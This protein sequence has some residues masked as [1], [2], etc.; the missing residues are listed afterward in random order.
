LSRLERRNKARQIAANKHQDVLRA[1]K[2]FDGRR[3]AAR[4]ISIVPLCSDVSAAEVVQRLNGSLDINVDVPASGVITIGIERF[5]QK[6][7][8]AIPPQQDFLAVLDACKL[9]DFVIFILSAKE[10]VDTHGESL[11]RA[12][13]SQG[14]SNV[15]TVVQHLDTVEPAK[16]RPDVRKSLLSFITHFFPTTE[17]VHS[18]DATQ[19]AQ[20][21]VRSL[22]TQNP[23]GIRWRDARS[24]ILAEEVR[25]NEREGLVVAGTVRGKGLKADRLV[26]IPG[27]GDYQIEKICGWAQEEKLVKPADDMSMDTDSPPTEPEVLE[28][29]TAAQDD[30]AELA[31]EEEEASQDA[32]M[33]DGMSTTTSVHTTNP[34]SVLLDDHYYFEEKEDE[35]YTHPRRLPKGTS[36]YQA[37]WILDSDFEESD[38]E[39]MEEGEDGD[40]DM[41]GERSDGEEE[42]R[43]DD[44]EESLVGES[45]SMYAPMEFGDDTKSEIFFDLP[46]EQEAEQIHAFRNR[47]KD[48][49]EDFEFPDEIELHPNVLA[50][51]RLARYRGLKSLR[52]SKWETAP[53]LP[54]QPAIWG[55]LAQIKN[56]A[57][58]RARVLNETLVGGVAAGTRVLIYIRNGPRKLAEQKPNIVAV[59]SLLRHEH[60][61]AVVHFSVMPTISGIISANGGDGEEEDPNSLTTSPVKSKDPLIIQCGPRRMLINPLFS[62]SS[63]P[64]KNDLYK[65]E[66]YLHPAR[67]SVAT[68]I[69]PLTF[70]SVPV[71]YFRPPAEGST[72]CT[73]H[74][75]AT[76]TS[77]PAT[78]RIIAKRIVLTGHPYKIHKRLVTVRFMFFNKEDVNYFKPVQL[79]TKRGRSGYIKES[80]GTHGWFKATFDGN[81]GAMDA[82]AMS[83]YKRVWPREAVPL[84][85]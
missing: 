51:E 77:L 54:H 60:K 26:H 14:V 80:L 63:A 57:A 76:G 20:N 49:M 22:C 85:A 3:G 23:K 58:T 30:L 78:P 65:F 52:S 6:V 11:L 38:M 46:P 42:A 37:A 68:T 35:R 31:P 41:R 4:I 13:E 75:V 36:N 83:L 17:K 79:Y 12:I 82:V 29:P 74:L 56:F 39:D 18:L 84:G 53:D 33:N 34:Q 25:W 47:Q 71:L 48:A 7:Q 2:L 45:Q 73:M 69:A 1:G 8:Y 9:A 67:T 55:R 24:Y 62:S 50:R 21:V 44:G 28:L 32:E 59:Y 64:T 72:N 10:E 19:E 61:K 16:R 15:V 27:Y 70:G 5:K 40:V 43:P 66:K 81:I